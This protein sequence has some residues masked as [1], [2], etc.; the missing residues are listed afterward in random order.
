MQT[1]LCGHAY[2]PLQLLMAETDR[3]A[4][5]MVLHKA[6]KKCAFQMLAARENIRLA[7]AILFH[8]G[9]KD[10]AG[11]D[12]S[13]T[14]SVIFDTP[15][16]ISDG[17]SVVS[18]RFTNELNHALLMAD[19]PIPSH[20]E[21]PRMTDAFSVPFTPIDEPMPEVK[22][23]GGFD[24]KL[25][26]MF[27]EQHCQNRYARIESASYPL[28]LDMRKNLQAALIWL[29]GSA[30]NK[31][32]TWTNIEKDEIMFHT[33]PFRVI[34]GVYWMLKQPKTIPCFRNTRKTGYS[35]AKR[36]F[37]HAECYAQNCFFV[38]F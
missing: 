10:K 36:L 25:R 31:D 18:E 4:D 34:C 27:K 3:F 9:S 30:E 37:R 35:G 11:S 22:L 28:S 19:A 16:L 2:I 21:T 15:K 29:G 26:T 12:D 24:V 1:L 38:R 14:L 23:A 33:I 32:V 5:P 8:L 7:F 6:L 13:G 20:R 17:T